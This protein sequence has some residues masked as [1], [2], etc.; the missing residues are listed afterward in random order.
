MTQLR[1]GII[2]CGGH[3]TVFQ[4]PALQSCEQIRLV[5]VVDREKD[6]AGKVARRFR[7]PEFYVDPGKLIGKVDAVLIA[8]PN[9]THADIA[10]PLLEQGIHV[11]CEKPICTSTADLN[12]MLESAA[13]SGA[14]LMAAHC[15]RFS[16][17]FSM[18]KQLIAAG[19]L[20]EIREIK[21]GIGGPYDQGIHRTDFRR[22][23][24]QS[25]GGVLID[26]GIHLI[27]LSLWLSGNP[28]VSVAYRGNSTQGW[29]VENN[30]EAAIEFAGQIRAT[31]SCSLTH[32]L[33]NTFT[34]RGRK[35]WARA[36]LY[37]STHLELFS[38]SARVCQK[39]GLQT[40]VL[41]SQSMYVSQIRHFCDALL[42]GTQ[43]MITTDEIRSGIEVIEKCYRLGSND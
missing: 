42:S 23:R 10:C 40:L 37:K 16:P 33:D 3:S 6:W 36:S 29:E 12:R 5:A 4:L 22:Q 25:G 19:W 2:G 1:F 20:G 21:A 34:V 9:T 39:N 38:E 26:L 32:A 35:G 14:R 11:L 30:A 15:L 8:T 17:N 31:V 43:F 24:G 18:L 27:D 13:R 28:P 41:P 7:V